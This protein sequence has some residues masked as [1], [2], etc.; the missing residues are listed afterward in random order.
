MS[1]YRI[2]KTDFV[3]LR[4]VHVKSDFLQSFLS[5]FVIEKSKIYIWEG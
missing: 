3:T 5:I 1:F 4:K 2:F